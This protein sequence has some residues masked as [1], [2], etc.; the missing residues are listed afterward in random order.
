MPKFYYSYSR[1]IDWILY[2]SYAC[3]ASGFVGLFAARCKSPFTGIPFFLVAVMSGL[4]CLY[5]AQ[6]AIEFKEDNRD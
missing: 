5:S 4:L 2:S 6:Q 1:F 3:V